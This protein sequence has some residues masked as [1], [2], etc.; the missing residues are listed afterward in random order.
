LRFVRD[1]LRRR[2]YRS[3]GAILNP[4]AWSVIAMYS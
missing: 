4:F 3:A 2:F 1:K